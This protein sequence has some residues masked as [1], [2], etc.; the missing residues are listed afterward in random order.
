MEAAPAEF[1]IIDRP[2]ANSGCACGGATDPELPRFAGDIEWLRWRGA[3]VRRLDPR[4]HRAELDDL[5]AARRALDERGLGALPMVLQN[6]EVV[7]SGS[8]PSRE[9][10]KAL[11]ESAGAQQCRGATVEE[12]SAWTR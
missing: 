5:P 9:S 2:G 12:R 4:V 8:Y 6:G 10:L 1:V 11:L 7:H 3:T